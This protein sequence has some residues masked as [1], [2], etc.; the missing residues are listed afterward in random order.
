MPRRWIAGV[1]FVGL[2]VPLAESNVVPRSYDED[3]LQVTID[4]STA[5]KYQC[6]S[7]ALFD[8]DGKDPT[9]EHVPLCAIDFTP[10][11]ADLLEKYSFAVRWRSERWDNPEGRIGIEG[12]VSNCAPTQPSCISQ[13]MST[14]QELPAHL[15]TS[16]DVEGTPRLTLLENGNRRALVYFVSGSSGRL[17]VEESMLRLHFRGSNSCSA[18]RCVLGPYHTLSSVRIGSQP[19]QLAASSD[20]QSENRHLKVRINSKEDLAQVHCLSYTGLALDVPNRGKTSGTMVTL[21]TIEIDS[22]AADL[23]YGWTFAVRWNDKGWGER[24]GRF[25]ITGLIDNCGTDFAPHSTGI[26]FNTGDFPS[27]V[28]TK[29]DEPGDPY[30]PRAA[31]VPMGKGPRMLTLYVAAFGQ[32][33]TVSALTLNIFLRSGVAYPALNYLYAFRRISE[34]PSQPS[35][36]LFAVANLPHDVL[37]EILSYLSPP[38]DKLLYDPH[39]R[40]PTEDVDRSHSARPRFTDFFRPKKTDGLTTPYQSLGIP[41]DFG[42]VFPAKVDLPHIVG[43]GDPCSSSSIELSGSTGSY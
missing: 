9:D 40:P 42:K 43:L 3:V 33:L 6:V 19:L 13:S 10:D 24:K 27:Q 37:K 23:L 8:F 4:A 2:E 14:I 1:D 12:L 35:D 38:L 39:S 20:L 11:A 31:N 28:G 5:E 17:I 16:A 29:C 30:L 21:C 26:D 18:A 25:G 32:G 36:F 41:V 7:F 15:G 34:R 22:A